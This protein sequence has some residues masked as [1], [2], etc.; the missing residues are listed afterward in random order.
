MGKSI[1]ERM[2]NVKYELSQVKFNKSGHNKHLNFKYH[3][4]Q[5]FLQTIS[6][7]NKEHGVNESISMTNELATMTLTATDDPN[8]N[9]TVTVPFIMADMQPKN[10]VIQ[11][12]GATLTYIRRYLYVQAYAITEGDQVDPQDL[13]KI[14]NEKQEIFK[15]AKKEVTDVIGKLDVPNETKN[16]ISVSLAKAFGFKSWKE[17]VVEDKLEVLQKL[18]SIIEVYKNE[19][20]DLPK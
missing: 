9:Y 18:E 8:D 15:V 1:H 13:D 4:L 20:E 3:E 14:D 10:D 6:K 19:S 5:D 17:F 16:I 11:K 2:T 12:L 7:L